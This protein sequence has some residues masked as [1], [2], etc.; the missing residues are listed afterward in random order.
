MDVILPKHKKS[1]KPQ[2]L[3]TKFDVNTSLPAVEK[4]A[5]IT[6]VNK[7]NMYT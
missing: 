5:Q 7:I 3:M 1:H 4:N 2:I 6:K